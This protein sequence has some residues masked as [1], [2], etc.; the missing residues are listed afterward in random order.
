MTT[1]LDR[2]SFLKISS[3]T[4]VGLPLLCNSAWSSESKAQIYRRL[5][6][7]Q[8]DL[9]PSWTRAL[10][11]R[12]APLDAPIQSSNKQALS[13]IGMTVGGI[14]C[15]TVYLAGDGRLYVWDIFHRPHTGVIMQNL[16][17]PEGFKMLRE[18]Q[19]TVRTID[20]ASY[21][22]PPTPDI[23]PN[24]F[25]Q[26]FTLET[27][28]DKPRHFD[29]QHWQNV[30]F[31]GT[32][33]LATIN[34]SDPDCPIAAKLEVWTPFIPLETNDSSIPVT[35]LEYT[36]TNHSNVP[37]T[38]R[39]TGTWENPV[40]I[41]SRKEEEHAVRSTVETHANHTIL[42]HHPE[43]ST[44]I[45]R[46]DWGSACLTAMANAHA[47]PSKDSLSVAFELPPGKS[48]TIRFLLTWHFPKMLKLDR[49]GKLVRQTPHYTKRFADAKVVAEH[50]TSRYESLKHSTFEWVRTWND[51]TL[52]QWLL[53]R[54]ILTTNTLQT[55]N[56][57]VLG[58]EEYPEGRFWAWE[59]IGCCP[60]TCTHVWHYAQGVARLF[61][62][63]E[64]NLREITDYGIGFNP[65]GSIH[66]RA[67]SNDQ[68]AIDGQ[69]GIILRTWREHLISADSAFLS[70]VW[71]SA[72]KA[73][74][75]LIEFDRKDRDGLDGLLDG[76]Q[77]NTLDSEWFGKVHC[78]CSL[79]LA[80]LRA[81]REMAKEMNDP[82]FE[83]KCA[84]VYESGSE[85]IAALFNGEFYE[86]QEDPAHL[87]KIGVGTGCYIDQVIGQWWAY[88]VGLGRIYNKNHIRSALNSLWKYNFA[89]HVGTFRKEFNIGR[90]YALGDEAG[91][92]M[93]TWPKG[94]LRD[95]L[96]KFPHYGYFNECMTGFEWQAAAHMIQEGSPIR[97]EDLEKTA[98]LI[99]D[100]NN[101]K[102]LTLRGLAIGRAIHDRYYP[103]KRNPYNEIEC[104]DH[105]ARANA[106]YSVFLAA[107]G[108]AY[109]GPKGIIEFNPKINP[110][111]FKAAFT[112]A[113]GWGSYQQQSTDGNWVAEIQLTHGSL[114]L[115][116]I[117]LQ[118][119]RSETQ[120][121][122][123]SRSMKSISQTDGIRTDEPLIMKAGDVLRITG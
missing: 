66:F 81:G 100:S 50:V 19:K 24:P 110:T 20:G 113:E 118:W 101:P 4:A 114:K 71:P 73:L 32:W 116:H 82:A 86:Q 65:D 103:E 78:L 41:H 7:A 44:P 13:H 36:L 88:Q 109:N 112:T 47:N 23:F 30:Q 1:P 95:D 5:I 76:E 79:Y 57:Q 111:R 119:L 25:R 31:Q 108:F 3:S 80:A 75:W 90:I 9:D 6:P 91:L 43:T 87:D 29:G 17:I 12:N 62:S 105:Y 16:P 93:C 83:A 85:K 63:L 61:P 45:D 60:G 67:E 121:M 40:L 28:G 58:G 49:P 27:E 33:P 46:S 96:K 14:G 94:G 89:P 107:C 2:R 18:S 22:K 84:K 92:I 59:G 69:T 55:T 123:N 97:E 122:M 120:L 74:G 15:G 39:V 35:I 72:R 70:R 64:R 52:P 102:A 26:H 53:D 21:I 42:H 38:G 56:C 104:S 77:H 37:I 99:E 8:K 51:S 98:A 10:A 48:T 68:T 54:T 106:S 11:Q 34:Y 115:Q 117:K